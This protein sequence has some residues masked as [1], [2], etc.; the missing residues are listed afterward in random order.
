MPGL[1]ELPAPQDRVPTPHRCRPPA[2]WRRTGPQ[3]RCLRRSDH[4][5]GSTSRDKGNGQ[6]TAHQGRGGGEIT[7][8]SS[9]AAAGQ[10]GA[11]TLRRTPALPPFRHAPN[12][13]TQHA[14][15]EHTRPS[16]SSLAPQQAGAQHGRYMAHTAARGAAVAA[17]RRPQNARSLGRAPPAVC[18][19][20]PRGARRPHN[21]FLVA[22]LPTAAAPLA[23]P[24]G[25]RSSGAQSSSGA[26]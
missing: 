26:R 17:R 11:Q 14:Q 6:E 5:P 3:G 25:N 24:A 23:S 9:G 22:V 12:T 13:S 19:Q 1:L 21:L 20:K 10:N 7:G 4:K 16:L 18:K 8:S 15:R 2:P